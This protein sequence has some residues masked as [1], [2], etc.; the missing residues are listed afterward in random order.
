MLPNGKVLT[1]VDGEIDT[2]YNR[3]G[4]AI[5]YYVPK[6]TILINIDNSGL[7]GSIVYNGT[8]N[9][10]LNGHNELISVTCPNIEGIFNSE[11]SE[12]L[13]NVIAP[14]VTSC[15]MYNC[16]LTAKSIGDILAQ[17]YFNFVDH[18]TFDFSGGTNATSSEVD[19]YLIESGLYEGGFDTLVY[20]IQQDLNGDITYN[21]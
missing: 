8:A 4:G 6:N 21:V 9:F 5:T 15:N 17:T 7:S 2:T 1:T 14:K 10:S 3:Y 13:A 20:Q 12:N 18:V 16:A 19:I 11:N